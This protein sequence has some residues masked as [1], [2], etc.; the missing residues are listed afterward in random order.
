MTTTRIATM[1]PRTRRVER[2][3]PMPALCHLLGWMW[4]RLAACAGAVAITVAADPVPSDWSTSAWQTGDGLPNNNIT[5]V[6]QSSDGYLWV[7]TFGHPA[8]FDGVHFEEFTSKSLLPLYAGYTARVSALLED[9][10]G[11]LWLAM[12][13]GPVVRLDAGHAEI[14]TNNLPDYLALN[15]A[16]AGD[17]S[18]WVVYHGGIVCRIA[19]GIVTRFSEQDGLPAKYDCALACDNQGRIWFAKN[20][21]VG[22]FLNDHFVTL[23]SDLAKSA[24]ITRAHRGGIWICSGRELFHCD[25]T[26]QLTSAGTFRPAASRTDP[27][28]LLEDRDDA[29]WIGTGSSGLFRYDHSGFSAV[30]TSH[31]FISS[32]LQDREG[33]LWVGTG[34]GGLNRIRP[35]AFTLES[36]RT[37]LP[38]DTVQSICEDAGG[39]TWVVTQNGILA[40]RTDGQWL[41]ITNGYSDRPTCV[42]ADSNNVYLGTRGRDVYRWNDGEWIPLEPTN[43]FAGRIAQG[44]LP[45][46]NGE[47]WIIQEDPET[48]QCL[49]AGQ[50]KTFTP[51]ASAGVLRAIAQDAKNNIWVGSSK[52]NLLRIKDD[53]MTD[54]TTNVAGGAMSIRTLATTPDGTLWIGY[55]S[56]GL[57]RFKDGHFFRITTTRGLFNDYISQIAADGL[58]WLWLNSDRGL[59]K[60]KL[61]ELDQVAEGRAD[62]VQSI[63]YG[64]G[65]ALPSL[66]AN[67]GQTPD[68]L[69]GRDG[70]LWFPARTALAVVTPQNLRENPEPPPV[71]LKQVTMDDNP[72]AAYGGTIPVE[73][74]LDLRQSATSLRLPPQHHQL[75][76]QFT[77]L[78][79]DAPENVHFQYRLA[80][81]DNRWLDAGSDRNARFPRLNAGGYRFEVRARNGVGPWSDPRSFSFDVD[82]FF[83]QTWWFQSVVLF[84]FTVCVIAVVRYISFRRLRLQLR[85]LEQVAALE[86]ERG[87]IARDIHDDIGGNLTQIKLLFELAVRKRTEPEKVDLL[88]KEGLA[89]TRQTIKSLDEIVWAINPNNDTLPHLV[90]YIGQFAIEFLSRA[91]I[92]CR[93]HLPET[94]VAWNVSPETRHNLFLV[95]KE[96]LNNVI[97]HSGAN[98]VWLQVVATEQ[99]LT[100]TIRDNGHGIGPDGAG[101]FADGLSNMNQRM[102]EIGGK[103]AVDSN[104]GNG[105]L[106]SF[107][108]PRPDEK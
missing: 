2:D 105:T 15:M 28:T 97:V 95:V 51:S 9:R 106:V 8:R 87:R 43:S 13:H 60:V 59:F 17:G 96:A 107:T 104:G 76:F 72:I 49:R 57:G 79:F 16:E 25:E 54:E 85:A 30:P 80:G 56:G 66:Q 23:A 31:S 67:F 50:L 78:C 101:S 45:T 100:L 93:V 34:G 27:T 84:A 68:V 14:F 91:G 86:K 92:R 47:L 48:I 37:G 65:D 21:Q 18:I 70:R 82:P 38:F 11:G 52:G 99:L 19:H 3:L 6:A 89:A 63:H 73:P 75:A 98:E 26:G 4:R 61:Q 5:S 53:V 108:L 44:L 41:T 74:L 83:W 69:L 46:A 77:A 62:R 71:L 33:N 102:A 12:V 90:E 40:C 81:F 24:V 55:A 36:T 32:L 94:P 10:H 29:V 42:A 58:G 88:G 103:A 20:G 35:R 7:A 64:E 22:V 39:S 1:K